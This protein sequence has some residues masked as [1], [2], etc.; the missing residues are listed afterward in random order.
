V[1]DTAARA[2]ALVDAKS[3][4]AMATVGIE[5]APLDV[6]VHSATAVITASHSSRLTV[7]DL[8]A[9]SVTGRIELP[10]AAE[11]IVVTHDGSRAYATSRD[12]G[13][14]FEVSLRQKTVSRTVRVD[15][16]PSALLLSPDESRLYVAS[17]GQSMVK[18]LDREKLELLFEIR[19]PSGSFP[20]ALALS[21]N[22]RTLLVALQGDDRD[23]G[24][25]AFVDLGSRRITGFTDVGG[26]PRGIVV[27]DHDRVAYVGDTRVVSDRSLPESLSETVS[28]VDLQT[29]RVD[30]VLRVADFGRG[31]SGMAADPEA[32]TVVL[33]TL[34]GGDAFPA[35]LLVVDATRRE[36]TSSMPAGQS[37]SGVAVVESGLCRRTEGS[38][39]NPMRSLR[40]LQRQADERRRAGRPGEAQDLYQRILAQAQAIEGA[41]IA[42]ASALLGLGGIRF[43]TKKFDDAEALWQQAADL[44]RRRLG[45]D[46]PSVATTLTCLGFAKFAQHHWEQARDFFE[47]A[48]RIRERALPSEH[49]DHALSLLNLAMVAVVA[50]G[51]AEPEQLTERAIGILTRSLGNDHPIVADALGNLAMWYHANGRSDEAERL[52]R[53]VLMSHERRFGPS[54]KDTALALGNL[55]VILMGQGKLEQAESYERRALAVLEQSQAKDSEMAPLLHNLGMIRQL[56]GD[57]DEASLLFKR[58]VK[59]IEAA[60]GPESPELILPLRN[61]AD[62]ESRLG[63]SEEAQTLYRRAAQ[64]SEKKLGAEDASL[65]HT[66]GNQAAALMEQGKPHEAEALARQAGAIEEKAHG[67]ESAEAA[68][69]MNNVA[70]TLAKQGRLDEALKQF[71]EA[72][73]VLEKQNGP[74]PAV[75]MTLNNIGEVYGMQGK[76]ADADSY[77]TRALK[78]REAVLGSDDPDI[79]ASLF[80]LAVVR[81]AQG[82]NGVAMQLLERAH[83]ILAKQPH[84]AP[85]LMATVWTNLGQLYVAQKST[86]WPRLSSNTPYPA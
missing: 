22:G 85:E 8:N 51:V 35:T 78:I 75:A 77:Y 28:V 43:D 7:V 36:V 74:A 17:A 70:A 39:E 83:G 58:A 31:P 65:G 44:F 30:T 13:S 73:A 48:L 29:R 46:H 9:L 26:T 52:Q 40:D 27:A 80:G 37:L 76:L 50:K 5:D 61:L 56:R 2:V 34:G 16:A 63:K 19:F 42:A 41:D 68:A 23:A 84:P 67:R 33:G 25:L 62:V 32:T 66:L 18:V 14:I 59:S 81:A 4:L 38:A 64:I 3:G 69:A 12:T 6:A 45:D 49:P 57:L 54:H 10:G 60:N 72:L 55:A 71:R 15:E 82:N 11:A 24:R 53:R 20:E 1:A 21:S 47:R 86:S 79:A